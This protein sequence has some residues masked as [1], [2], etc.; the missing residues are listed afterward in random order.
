MFASM[1]E[2][3]LIGAIGLALVVTLLVLIVLLLIQGC[4]TFTGYI[5]NRLH[6][7]EQQLLLSKEST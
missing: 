6:D 3:L 4:V 1:T 2:M 5:Q 7:P